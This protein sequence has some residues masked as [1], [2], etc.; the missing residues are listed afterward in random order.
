MIGPGLAAG[1]DAE[2][3]PIAQRQAGHDHGGVVLLRAVDAIGIL[4]VHR[5]LID[6]RGRLIV[7][8][9][10]GAAAIERDVGAAVVRL[11]S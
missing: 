7:L 6:F 4:I 5:D 11:G 3:L 1:T 2:I 10:P 8:R 9:A